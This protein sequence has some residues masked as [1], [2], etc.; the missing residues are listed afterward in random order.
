MTATAS[1]ASLA[2]TEGVV[3][4]HRGASRLA[5]ENTVNAFQTAL[6]K[7]A[8]ALELDVHLTSDDQLVVIHDSHLDRT[9]SGTGAVRSLSTDEV[10][11]LDAGSWYGADFAGER[12]PTLDEVLELTQGR[13]RLNIELKASGADRVAERVIETVCRHAAADRVVVMSF[14]LDSVLAARR[15]RTSARWHDEAAPIVVLPIVTQP[16]ADPLAFVRATGMDGLNYPPRLWDAE[17]IQRF[18]DSD[19]TVHGGLI[20]DPQTMREFFDC[21]GHMADTDE[22]DLFSSSR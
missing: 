13:A 9:T 1:S 4:A 2:R 12:V 5:P 17:L 10:Q 8:A 20:N 11:A 21:G 6:S 14:S 3:A 15:H 22:P 16:L 19:L 18:R 7:G